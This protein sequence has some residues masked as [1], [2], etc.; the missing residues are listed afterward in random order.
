MATKPIPV[1][2]PYPIDNGASTRTL[3]RRV[4]YGGKKGRAA[5][6]RLRA[7]ESRVAPF[8]NAELARMHRNTVA[9]LEPVMRFA[10]LR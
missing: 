8:V 7:L 10:G 4:A 2:S 3:W 6:K 1:G 9:M 5:C